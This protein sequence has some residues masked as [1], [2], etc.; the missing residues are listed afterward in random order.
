M[1]R[2][3]VAVFIC[4]GLIPTNSDSAPSASVRAACLDDA[5]KF[6]ASVIQDDAARRRCMTEHTAELS[7]GCKA[8][9]A[10]QRSGEGHTANVNRCI[11]RCAAL[12]PGARSSF[13]CG[14]ACATGRYQ[15]PSGY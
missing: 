2:L 13:K 10:A 8:A 7:D 12:S 11:E 15:R 3:L 1:R 4:V 9:V 5:K 14:E 6:C